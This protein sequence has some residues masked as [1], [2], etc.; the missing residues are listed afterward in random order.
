MGFFGWALGIDKYGAAQSALIAKHMFNQM[1]RDEKEDIRAKAIDVLECG[2][3]PR[4]DAIRRINTLR[5]PERYCLYSTTM[6]MAGIPPTLKG[7]LHKD[8]WY[9]IK[10]PFSA[11]LNAEKQLMAAKYEIFKMHGIEIT[12]SS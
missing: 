9:P 2:G 1:S 4:L 6:S 5:E 7:I 3:Y 11:L 12:L 8:W 10:N